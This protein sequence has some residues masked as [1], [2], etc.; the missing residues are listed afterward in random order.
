MTAD[1]LFLEAAV[2]PDQG[3]SG[4]EWLRRVVDHERREGEVFADEV[5]FFA[6]L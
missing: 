6:G 5:V 2:P 4:E 1:L 3:I